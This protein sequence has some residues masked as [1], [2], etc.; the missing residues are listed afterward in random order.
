MDEVT[1]TQRRHTHFNRL[2]SR[3]RQ[4][5]TSVSAQLRHHALCCRAAEVKVRRTLQRK[6]TRSCTCLHVYL[7]QRLQSLLLRPHLRLRCRPDGAD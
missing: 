5:K 2:N 1:Q 6:L 4:L 7:L 3:P